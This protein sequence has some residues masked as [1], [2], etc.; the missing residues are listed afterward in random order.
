LALQNF[1]FG[2][3]AFD[4]PVVLRKSPQGGNFF[5]RWKRFAPSGSSGIGK[6]VLVVGVRRC[7]I[8]P[9]GLRDNSDPSNRFV[10]FRCS[11]PQPQNP[12]RQARR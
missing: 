12:D 9:R 4:D 7:K 8:P 10:G 6:D 5:C 3:E 1:H 2:V 11:H